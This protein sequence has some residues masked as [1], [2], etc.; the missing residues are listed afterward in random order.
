MT[1]YP[2][3]QA[4]DGIILLNK[5]IGLSSNGLLQ[6]VK[7]LFQAQKAGHTGSL[8]PLATG[9]L[10][11]CFGEATKISS[12]LLD[13]DKTYLV[14]GH[15]GIKTDTGDAEGRVIAKV[16]HFNLT[17]ANV[18]HVL[19]QFLGAQMQIPPIYSALKHEGQPLYQ[20]ARAGKAVSKPARAINIHTIE[21]LSFDQNLITLRVSCSKGTYI[22]TLID[23]IGEALNVYAYVKSLHRLDVGGF[24]ADA[25][26]SYEELVNMTLNQRLQCLQAIDKPISYMPAITLEHEQISLLRQGR[27][28]DY[29][30]SFDTIVR[31]YD[32][33]Q[34]FIG[35]GQLNNLQLKVKRL[36]RFD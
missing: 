7:H 26:Y 24:A 8:D 22:R 4:L 11:I 27:I 36:L 19:L 30:S 2:K 34:K 3:K 20:L 33:N 31:L 5:P 13:A 15:L 16:E 28:L 6:R 23:D 21:L 14:T 35:L 17:E 10:P 9:M 12:Y 18:K 1:Q 29:P 25:M 32:I